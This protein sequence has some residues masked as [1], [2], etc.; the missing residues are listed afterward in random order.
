MKKKGNKHSKVGIIIGWIFIILLGIAPLPD[1]GSKFFLIFPAVF[2]IM[3]ATD[4]GEYDDDYY[5]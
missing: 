4:T 3:L 2:L 1:E 5:I